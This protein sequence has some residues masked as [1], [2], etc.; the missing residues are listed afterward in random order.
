MENDIFIFH[1]IS[2]CSSSLSKSSCQNSRKLDLDF[3]LFQKIPFILPGFAFTRSEKDDENIQ[4]ADEN[5]LQ[6]ENDK[7]LKRKN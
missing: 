1:L 6:E 4:C 2:H 5:N 7:I 3:R